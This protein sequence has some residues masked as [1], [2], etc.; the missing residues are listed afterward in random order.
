MVSQ[1]KKP[2]GQMVRGAMNRL[3]PGLPVI[4]ALQMPGEEYCALVLA[5][6]CEIALH[7]SNNRSGLFVNYDQLPGAV[8]GSIAKHFGISFSPEEIESMNSAAKFDAKTPS[9]PFASDN[10]AKQD[11]A[12]DAVRSAAAI[13]LDPLYERL[14]AV[15]R[16]L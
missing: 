6:F 9:L 1:I 7:H 16:K 13:W 8:T 2:G 11:G 12:T 3:L 4:E 10:Q 15:S 5:R 14:E